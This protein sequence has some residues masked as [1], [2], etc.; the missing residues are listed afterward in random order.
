MTKYN[1]EGIE[2]PSDGKLIIIGDVH[3]KIDK[4][5][6]I[7]QK[8]KDYNSIQVG[9]FGFSDEHKWHLENINSEKHKI[10]FGNH[11]DYTY[12]NSPHSLG[13]YS[14]LENGI[15][16]LRGALSI[17]K[18]NLT[19]N[20]DWFENEELNY[21][22]MQEA[23]DAYIQNKPRIMIT[24]D[25][26]VE[27]RKTLFNIS[28]KTMTSNGLQAMFEEHQPEIWIFGHHHKS[29]DVVINK[30]RFICLDELETIII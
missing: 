14:V 10:N 3:T 30:T 11:D 7:L 27:I 2:S 24:H 8:Y 23:I 22:E 4:Y 6:E 21:G 5:W 18:T 29:M 12:L 15:M 13:N 28:D 19:E 25:C 20:I 1:I 17:D 26:P 9:D 16:T